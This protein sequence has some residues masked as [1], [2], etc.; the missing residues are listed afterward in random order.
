VVSLGTI[1]DLAIFEAKSYF[2]NVVYFDS[3]FFF[4]IWEFQTRWLW[5]RLLEMSLLIILTCKLYL[6]L[7]QCTK[8]ICAEIVSKYT[9]LMNTMFSTMLT[10]CTSI[11]RQLPEQLSFASRPT[12]LTSYFK[13]VAVSA[14]LAFLWNFFRTTAG[15]WWIYSHAAPARLFAFLLR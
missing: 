12:E 6:R 1:V 8:L 5:N 3:V 11:S 7:F 10:L 4:P 14:V 9:T 2:G 13:C 15:Y